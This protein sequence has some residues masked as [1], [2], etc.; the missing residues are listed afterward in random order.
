M[1]KNKNK[2]PQQQLTPEKYIRLK[3]RNLP[4]VKCEITEDWKDLEQGPFMVIVTR[5]HVNGNF[6][7]GVYLVDIGCLGVK[8]SDFCFNLLKFEYDDFIEEVKGDVPFAE[9]SYSEAHNIIYG[10][11]SY[12]E[13]L[14]IEPHKSFE[15]TEYLLDE[16]TDDFPLIEYEF[17]KNGKPYLVANDELEAS[18]YLSILEDATGGDFEY[19]ILDDDNDD[20]DDNDDD[21]IR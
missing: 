14:G 20:N 19:M 7:C 6:T 2:Q 9:I 8:D 3:G 15:L 17:G 1:A 4:I 11:V 5:Q 13:E 10:A 16:D 12:A 18:R 21:L